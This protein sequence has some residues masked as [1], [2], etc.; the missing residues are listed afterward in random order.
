MRPSGG[1]LI[2][3]SGTFSYMRTMELEV[4]QRRQNA[5]GYFDMFE[6]SSLFTEGALL[7]GENYIDFS[8]E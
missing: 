5:A 3:E 8:T 2:R 1:G 7:C 6:R 4:E